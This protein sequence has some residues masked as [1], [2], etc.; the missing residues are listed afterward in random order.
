[1]F[2]IFLSSDDNLLFNLILFFGFS[3]NLNV[4]E[5]KCIDFIENIYMRYIK[6]F[7]FIFNDR[8]FKV[9]L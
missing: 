3:Y 1:M 4:L 9:I 8:V 2:Y 5:K 6:I 7:V